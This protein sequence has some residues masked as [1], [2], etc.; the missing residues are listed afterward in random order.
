MKA[1]QRRLFGGDWTKEK[2]DMLGAYL[3][4]YATAMKGQPLDL[5]LSGDRACAGPAR[6]KR[7]GLCHGKTDG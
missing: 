1:R 2:L 7:V 3:Q 5:M 6:S 4:A